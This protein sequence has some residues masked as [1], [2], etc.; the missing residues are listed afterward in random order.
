MDKYITVLTKKAT[1]KTSIVGREDIILKIR[2][3]VVNDK[4]PLL[5]V[6]GKSGVGKTTVVHESL[7]NLNYVYHDTEQDSDIHEMS[8]YHVLVED[9]NNNLINYLECKNRLSLGTTILIL[10]NPIEL[11]CETIEITPLSIVKLQ[12]I[13][14]CHKS[15]VLSAGNIHNFKF[16]CQSSDTKDVFRSSYDIVSNLLCTK[17]I[18]PT[19]YINKKFDDRG[20]IW[21]IIH[22]NYTD[23]DDIDMETVSELASLADIIDTKLYKGYNEMYPMFNMFGIIMP[24]I[25][26]KGSLNFEKLRPGSCWT[27]FNN[28]KMREGKLKLIK[29]KL[30][31]LDN[32][33]LIRTYIKCN[34]AKALEHVHTYKLVSG[35]IDVINHLG[36]QNKIKSTTLQSFKKILKF[37]L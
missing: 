28:F 27:K 36:I 14:P 2:N 7:R 3:L 11:K 12:E 17:H 6:Y 8:N 24:S 16:Y 15:A 33:E 21:S 26:I 31:H 10:H 25:Y 18:E 5:M 1:E 22:E 34:R 4:I 9:L 37:S 35:D 19:E 29:Y 20:Y 13:H 30:S 32:I 23:Y